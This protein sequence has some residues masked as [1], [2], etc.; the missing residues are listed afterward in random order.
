MFGPEWLLDTYKFIREDKREYY[1]TMLAFFPIARTPQ[2]RKSSSSLNTHYRNV[3]KSLKRMT[4]WVNRR[5]RRRELAQ[6]RKLE[7]GKLSVILEP[8]ETRDN[9]IFKDAKI[10]N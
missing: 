10:V 1:E 9:P 6:H 3:V 7:P 2:D 8:G 5:E 4:P